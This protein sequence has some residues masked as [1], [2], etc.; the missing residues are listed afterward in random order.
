M[1]LDE[2]RRGLARHQASEV[3]A[4]KQAAVA[5]VVRPTPEGLS[6]LFIKRAEVEGDPWSGHMAFPGGR[7]EPHDEDLLE[8]AVRETREELGLSLTGAT[9]L[10]RLD[11]LQT[12]RK[13]LMVRP[14]V[15][16][17]DAEPALVPNR[18]VAKTLWSPLGPLRSGERDASY[19]FER[20]GKRF[21]FPAYDV[22]GQLVW[23]LTYR[24]LRSLFRLTP[25]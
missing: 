17:L 8:T 14:Y 6:A 7:H 1:D 4:E 11:D 19:L 21:E 25:R 3:R 18:E 12:H 23:G 10:G 15:F 24:M 22:R 13:G 16:A 20:E 9:L 2:L 5:A